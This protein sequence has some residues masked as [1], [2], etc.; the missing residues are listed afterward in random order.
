[1]KWSQ[2]IAIVAGC[3]LIAASILVT[4]RWQIAAAGYGY[5]GE[6]Q[7]TE[8]EFVY[9]LDRWTGKVDVCDQDIERFRTTGE[10]GETC[11]GRLQKP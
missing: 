2:E 7:G 10:V 8:R 6:P 5:N 1:M 11:P 9:R 4:N 3:A